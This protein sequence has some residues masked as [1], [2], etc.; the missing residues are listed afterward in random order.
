MNSIF[1]SRLWFWDTEVVQPLE[2]D[3]SAVHTF[4]R[5]LHIQWIGTVVL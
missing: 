2:S 1:F 3:A 5:S 4:E